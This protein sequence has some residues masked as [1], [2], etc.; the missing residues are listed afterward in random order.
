MKTAQPVAV[1]NGRLVD[2]KAAG[3]RLHTMSTERLHNHTGAL[4]TAFSNTFF[5]KLH[6]IHF[7][8]AG[9]GGK[10]SFRITGFTRTTVN[11]T[12]VVRVWRWRVCSARF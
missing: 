1:L 4:S 2:A 12:M 5:E 10:S 3:T 7:S 9:E 8:A 11:G 6:T